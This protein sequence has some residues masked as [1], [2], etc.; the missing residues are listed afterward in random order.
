MIARQVKNKIYSDLPG[1]LDIEWHRGHYFYMDINVPYDI[2]AFT[3]EAAII[4]PNSNEVLAY[5][6]VSYVN[7]TA[8]GVVHCSMEENVVDSLPKRSDW[9]V[10]QVYN[11]RSSSFLGGA[12][13][14]LN[15]G[16][17]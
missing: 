15:K 12:F 3:F 17:T 2:S 10:D 8:S 6:D 16:E 4:D 11:G 1:G 7:A 14:V 9:Y 13:T 5:M